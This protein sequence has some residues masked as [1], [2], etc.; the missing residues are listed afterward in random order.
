MIPENSNIY[1]IIVARSEEEFTTARSL[2]LEYE[3]E[4]DIDLCF[5]DFENEINNL[6]IQYG[7][8]GG[9][10]LLLKHEKD[11]VG[12]CGLRKLKKNY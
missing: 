6:S 4:L 7:P 5:Q 11:F 10:I 12:C 8:P 1:K 9:L 3:K 2:F